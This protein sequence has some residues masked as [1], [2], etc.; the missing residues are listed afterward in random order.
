M[1]PAELSDSLRQMVAVLHAERQ[2]LAGFDLEGIL[3]CAAD[4]RE[5]C[6]RIDTAALS[7]V[8]EDCRALLDAA[9]RMNEVNRQVRNLIAANVSAR[10][11]AL[12]GAGVLYRQPLSAAVQPLRG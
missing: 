8:D 9:R 2:S 10:L 5:L 12:T 11:D 7:E 3:G 6:G 1:S 4:K